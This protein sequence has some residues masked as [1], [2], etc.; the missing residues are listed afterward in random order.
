MRQLEDAE[1]ISYAYK[2]MKVLE[3]PDFAGLGKL[4]APLPPKTLSPEVVKQT[5]PAAPFPMALSQENMDF[6]D[7]LLREENTYDTPQQGRSRFHPDESPS[8]LPLVVRRPFSYETP[9]RPSANQTAKSTNQAI[10]LSYSSSSSPWPAPADDPDVTATEREA[11]FDPLSLDTC[12]DT[13]ALE[14][15]ENYSDEAGPSKALCIEDPWTCLSTQ[16]NIN[17]SPPRPDEPFLPCNEYLRER[18][19]P[20]ERSGADFYAALWASQ[21]PPNTTRSTHDEDTPIPVPSGEQNLY[22]YLSPDEPAATSQDW[23]ICVDHGNGLDADYSSTDV[24]FYSETSQDRK[25]YRNDWKRGSDSSHLEQ[26]DIETLLSEELCEIDE[27]PEAGMED[28]DQNGFVSGTHNSNLLEK[29]TPAEDDW[30]PNI[31]A[32]SSRLEIRHSVIPSSSILSFDPTLASGSSKA[33]PTRP[34]D[35]AVVSSQGSDNLESSGSERASTL[36]ASICS[37]SSDDDPLDLLKTLDD[38]LLSEDVHFNIEDILDGK[39]VPQK[40]ALNPFE[41]LTT[42]DA[43]VSGLRSFEGGHTVHFGT[44][45]SGGFMSPSRSPGGCNI[46]DVL[47]PEDLHVPG[48]PHVTA[49]RITTSPHERRDK[50]LPLA[51][52][53]ETSVSH[54]IAS[55]QSPALTL[56]AGLTSANGRLMGPSLFDDSTPGESEDEY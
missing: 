35:E 32:F 26:D 16:M 56:G 28:A 1:P 52:T 46:S 8:I 44:G 34:R 31:S 10:P 12:L 20:S 21:Y 53:A 30:V 15:S 9:R 4:S 14:S 6:D 3:L 27:D 47:S 54:K 13:T 36:P 7:V 42:K 29:S 45:L 55:M 43:V 41:Q 24:N 49:V 48:T 18:L 38:R 25:P 33:R 5:S 50:S 2:R 19:P 17:L 40:V 23:S 39:E 22:D 51:K 37:P 11:S